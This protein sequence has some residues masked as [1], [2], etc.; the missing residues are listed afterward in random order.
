MQ[1]GKFSRQEA[2]WGKGKFV[3][4]PWGKSHPTQW[5]Y[6][7]I[8]EPYGWCTPMS[9]D[10]AQEAGSDTACAG[11]IDSAPF[12]ARSAHLIPDIAISLPILP[13]TCPPSPMHDL[14]RGSAG[15]HHAQNQSLHHRKALYRVSSPKCITEQDQRIRG[16]GASEE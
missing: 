7:D 1:W 2:P 14:A 11:T 10:Q 8:Q 6:L 9:A 3:P 5:V 16:R 15:P 12:Q 13:R 4:L